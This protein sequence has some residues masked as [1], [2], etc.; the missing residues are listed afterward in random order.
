LGPTPIHRLSFRGVANP[1]PKDVRIVADDAVELADD[2]TWDD[3]GP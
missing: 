2:A 3:E 1:R